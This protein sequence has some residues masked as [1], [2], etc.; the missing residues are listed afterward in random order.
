MSGLTPDQA[1]ELELLCSAPMSDA[2]RVLQGA[3]YASGEYHFSRGH[4]FFWA[5]FVYVGD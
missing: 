2:Q 5:P 3:S 4:P 1:A